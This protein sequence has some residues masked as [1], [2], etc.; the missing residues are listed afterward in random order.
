MIMEKKLMYDYAYENEKEVKE[1]EKDAYC[2][3]EGW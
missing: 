2:D 3:S 1:V